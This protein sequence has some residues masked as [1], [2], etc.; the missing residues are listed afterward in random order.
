[1]GNSKILHLVT[2]TL[3]AVL[4]LA[5]CRPASTSIP[6][7]L[8]KLVNKVSGINEIQYTAVTTLINTGEVITMQVWLKVPKIRVETK[9]N[10][11]DTVLLADME[12]KT[13]YTYI[14]VGGIATKT[15]FKTI[16]SSI[17]ADT[18][19][20]RKYNPSITGTETID[21]K[22]CTVIMC[23][24]GR[25]DIKAWIWNDYGIIIRR[26]IKEPDR[27]ALIEMK[28]ID[29]SEIPASTFELPEGVLRS[30]WFETPAN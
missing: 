29:F 3:M 18:E 8:E 4:L 25:T 13:G 10:G 1:M 27:E 6:P 24:D 19:A 9:M 26:E 22:L 21:G 5:G 30:D 23:K 17:Q 2:V 28:G 11:R 20:L 14:P 7:E 12:K 16:P 15:D